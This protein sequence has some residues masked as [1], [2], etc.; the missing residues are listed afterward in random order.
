MRFKKNEIR[1]IK[2]EEQAIRELIYETILE[3]GH[4]YFDFP[5]KE[6]VC[7]DVMLDLQHGKMICVAHV[8]EIP[9]D[10]ID[11][12][13][14]DEKIEVTTDSFFLKNCYVSKNVSLIK[15]C[16]ER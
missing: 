11:Y 6:H 2:V 9:F 13:S 7:Y 15:D 12:V 14:L 10:S 16:M 1:V 8:E 5:E 3:K 4:L